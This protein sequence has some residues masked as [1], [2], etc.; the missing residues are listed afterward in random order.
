[1]QG[2]SIYKSAPVSR[3]NAQGNVKSPRDFR[4][5]RKK[6][7]TAITVVILI[8]GVILW[9]ILR[10]FNNA[11][12]TPA[13]V[14]TSSGVEITPDLTPFLTQAPI[15]TINETRNDFTVNELTNTLSIYDQ[16]TT[17]NIKVKVNSFVTVKNFSGFK[18][19]LVFTNGV[20][21]SLKQDESEEMYFSKP[22]VITFEDKSYTGSNPN[23]RIKGEITVVE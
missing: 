14:Q 7:L 15:P 16:V 13:T 10:F 23:L 1:M 12:D 4:R 11:A 5:E 8:F 19:H 22:G 18:L 2:E 17:Y 3:N 20:D 9:Y 21:L 6:L